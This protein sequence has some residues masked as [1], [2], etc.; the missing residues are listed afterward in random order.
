MKLENPH[1]DHFPS[2]VAMFFD[3]AARGGEDPFLWRKADRV[4]HPLSWR[5]VANQVSALAHNLREL[6]LKDGDRVVLISENRPEWCI[7]DLAIMAAGCV[8]VPTYTTNTERDHQH[9]LD[10]SGAKAVIVSTAKLART[11]MPAVTRSDA[12]IVIRPGSSNTAT[13]PAC[14]RG[15][16]PRPAPRSTSA[17]PRSSARIRPA[18]SIPAAPAAPRAA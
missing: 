16:L 11:L 17:W 9:I 10:N 7:A 3:R 6:G 15:M 12:H 4:W 13:G 8:T 5:Q 1:L 2:L 14:W 18:S